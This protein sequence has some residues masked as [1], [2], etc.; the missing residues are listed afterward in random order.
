MRPRV[1]GWAGAAALLLLSIP[2]D[3]RLYAQGFDQPNEDWRNA[4]AY[5]LA[6]SQATDGAIFYS[7]QCRMPF[8]FYAG[9]AANKPGTI[10]PAHAT[11]LSYL[12]FM[13]KPDER[14]LL[15]LNQRTARLW[16]VMCHNQLPSGYDA[17][18]EMIRAALARQFRLVSS[19]EFPGV[20]IERYER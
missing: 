14:L 5:V 4:T 16:L 20:K 11:T 9:G 6:R 18:T 15:S 10:F 8:D 1:L 12:D 2:A 17:N 3:Q 19:A 7:S 13:G